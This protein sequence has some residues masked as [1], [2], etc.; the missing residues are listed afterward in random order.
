MPTNT[1][2]L[3]HLQPRGLPVRGL[4]RVLEAKHVASVQR[5]PNV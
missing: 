2:P 5:C 4:A 3:R 1:Y